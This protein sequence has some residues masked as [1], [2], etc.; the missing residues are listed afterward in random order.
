ML[1][2]TRYITLRNGKV[3]TAAELGKQVICFHVTAEQ[4]ADYLARQCAKKA[5]TASK[6]TSS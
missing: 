4:Y 5:R 3:L 2:C 1:I 6:E